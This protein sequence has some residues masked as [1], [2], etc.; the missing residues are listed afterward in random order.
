VLRSS[1]VL[2][3]LTRRLGH[4]GLD[5]TYAESGDYHPLPPGPGPGRRPL[6]R[7]HG[8]RRLQEHLHHPAGE[9]G[10]RPRPFG[11]P[12]LRRR[13]PQAAPV[14]RPDRGRR[15]DRDPD[16]P[17]IEEASRFGVIGIDGERRIVEFMEK[18]K[19]PF[20]APLGPR[21]RA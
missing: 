13:L 18:P 16:H 8:R 10:G 15:P 19:K 2:L 1:Y 11:R 9:P 5:S 20:A 3:R 14:L 7:R 21:A 6:V 17:A 4:N 12:R